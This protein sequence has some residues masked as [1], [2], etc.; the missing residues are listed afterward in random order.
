MKVSILFTDKQ[1]P[2]TW[3]V[4]EQRNHGTPDL[5]CSL[6]AEKCSITFVSNTERR[7]FSLNKKAIAIADVGAQTVHC[8]VKGFGKVL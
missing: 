3:Y 7:L 8:V 6:D 1:K 5:F 2:E 4:D